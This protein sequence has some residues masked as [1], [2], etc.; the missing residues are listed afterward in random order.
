MTERV[1]TEC[2]RLA[3]V[4]GGVDVLRA[5]VRD[6]RF[7][8]HF[9]EDYTFG[10]VTRGANR[11]RYGH[12]RLIAPAGTLCL[13]VPGEIHTGEADAEGWTY[14]TIHVSPV[15]LADLSA[16]CGWGGGAPDFPSGVVEDAE[17][18]SLFA[19]LFATDADAPL[20]AVEVRVVEALSRMISVHA[21]RRRPADERPGSSAGIARE[22]LFDRWNENPTLADLE[23]ATG[24]GARRLIGDFKAAFG[25]PPHAWLTRLRACRARA[26]ILSGMPIAH[27][28][29]EAGFAD[30][31]HL[32]RT[33]RRFLGHTPGALVSGCRIPPFPADRRR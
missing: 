4:L 23:A 22:L 9:H 31:S 13:A 26:M 17:A 8:P 30:Q 33:F 29:V 10:L 16:R 32:T 5:D 11:F 2:R 27:A 25:L 19:R 7:D 1:R 12:R 21:A 15:A 28:A 3:G 24:V 6:L 18:A 20:L 14:W